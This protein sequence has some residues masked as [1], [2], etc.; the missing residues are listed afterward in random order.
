MRKSMVLQLPGQWPGTG[1]DDA[2]F[3][4]YRTS[5]VL[6]DDDNPIGSLFYGD[7]KEAATQ[8]VGARVTVL[9]P[10]EDVLLARAQLPEMK[11][12]KLARAV[13]FALEEQL[14]NDAEDVHVAIGRRDASGK[15]AN[16]VIL[17]ETIDS[18]LSRLREAGL[19]PDVMSPEVFGVHW[20]SDT[21]TARWTL[22]INGTHA[23]LRTGEQT[24][25]AFD[26]EN[27]ILVLRAALNE[28]GESMP[29]SLSIVICGDEHFDGP[30]AREELTALCSERSVELSF[31]QY[32]DS[33][34]LLLAQGFDEG[35]AINLLQGDYSRK[36]QLG[37]FL[38][39][40]KSALVLGA[41]MI[42]LQVG[43]FLVDYL[44]L[45][46]LADEQQAEIESLFK[47]AMPGSRLVPGR[48]KDL[49][50]QALAKLRGSGTNQGLLGLLAQSGNIFRETGGIVLRNLRYRDGKMDVDMD[51]PDLQSLDKLKQRLTSEAGL[52]VDIVSASQRDGKVE[53]RLTLGGGST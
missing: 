15:L 22:V 25:M 14:A 30:P 27:I 49:M 9:V 1:E 28:A 52:K 51:I 38:R 46:S 10:G 23:L 47:A 4:E 29:S 40:W 34:N 31:Q 17:R 21:E 7:L 36:E 2:S 8:A 3:E 33:C 43:I 12:Q 19:H 11:G 32:D 42:V 45:S 48:E 16:A 13:P 39:P 6:R 35:H 37:K 53:C 5:W 41:I 24:G 26:V 20:D 50:E 18:W 44:R